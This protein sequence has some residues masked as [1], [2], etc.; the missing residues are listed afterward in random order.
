MFSDMQ[1]FRAIVFVASVIALLALTRWRRV[2]PFIAIMAMAAAFGYI[3][4]Y[5]I[6]IIVRIFGAGFSEMIYAPGLVIVAAGLIAGLAETTGASDRLMAM[7]NGGGGRPLRSH[8]IAAILGLVAGL[9]ASPSG[10]FALLSPLLRPIGG[11][12]Q[13]HRQGATVALGLAL[14]ASHGLMVFSP[15][16]IAAI[17]IV[18][19]DWS[20]TA[21]VGVPLAILLAGFAALFAGHLP[22][23]DSALP[24]TE[25]PVESAPPAT[26]QKAGAWSAL[27][28]VLAAIV[29][30]LLLMVASL[31][32]I[33]SEPL[34]GEPRLDW[35]IA[36][37]RPLTLFVAGLGVMVVGMPRA[38]LKLLGD[39]EWVGR[40]LANVASTLLIVCAAGGF[41]ALCQQTGMSDGL[42]AR[43]LNWHVAAFLGVLVAFLAS[44]V[45][46]TLQG[47]SLLAVIASAGMVQPL[48]TQL[49]LADTNGKV[50][51]ALAV[52][53][54][55][56]TVS[57]VN[58][59]Y[60]WL[61]TTSAGY[62]PLRGI[63]TISLGTLLQGLIAVALLL[64]AYAVMA[65]I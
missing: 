6:S 55:A 42:G 28:L 21:L 52:G 18:G 13:A 61:V 9:G 2:H 64:V 49:G 19:A 3:A 48:L 62:S 12:S 65:H 60:F 45:M 20:R 10:A 63:A 44:A 56:M 29:P 26:P 54:G 4:L 47:S 43:V 57:H 32:D 40:I 41:Q 15:V 59:D 1:L 22:A 11:K 8:W 17:S 34:G 33:P 38:S 7:F 53:M 46:K 37:G 58:D 16:A 23:V 5:R 50:L 36:I 31:G 39:S 24:A 35:I 14:S 25:Q 27:L 51:A 30:L